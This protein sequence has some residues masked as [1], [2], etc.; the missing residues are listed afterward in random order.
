M[1]LS[2]II[3]SAPRYLQLRY[4]GL[5]SYVWESLFPRKEKNRILSKIKD[6]SKKKEEFVRMKEVV[7]EAT[8]LIFIF[9]TK[10][11]F[12]EGSNAAKNAVDTLRELGVK[13]FYLGDA[14]FAGRNENVVL[15]DKLADRLFA[16]LNRDMRSLLTDSI[17]M[18]DIINKYK[19]LSK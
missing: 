7:D 17:Y 15:G 10:K 12:I 3:K 5:N 6:E 4:G 18:S 8:L 9:V 16:S 2:S 13:E 11:I 19:T 14:K 1:N